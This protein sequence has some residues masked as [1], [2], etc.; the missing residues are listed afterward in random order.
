[1]PARSPRLSSPTVHYVTVQ[2]PKPEISVLHP[3]ANPEMDLRTEVEVRGRPA[4]RPTC[5]AP[6]SHQ[7]PVPPAATPEDLL[8]GLNDVRPHV[9]HFFQ[10]TP[11]DAAVLFDNASVDSPEGRDVPFELLARA[12]GATAETAE[13]AGPEWLRLPL[14]EPRSCLRRP[15]DHQW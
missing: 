2:P 3:T 9:V 6:R 12:L 14:T 11:G 10:V 7:H 5:V 15:R 1:M 13:V 4:G 8:D